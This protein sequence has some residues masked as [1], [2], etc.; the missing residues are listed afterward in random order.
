MNIWIILVMPTLLTSTSS[1]RN[2]SKQK[3]LARSARAI[4]P[5][6]NANDTLPAGDDD[7]L[8]AT[9]YPPSTTIREVIGFTAETGSTGSP[10]LQVRASPPTTG[11]M[12]G[13]A[14]TKPM[15]IVGVIMLLGCAGGGLYLWYL[16]KAKMDAEQADGADESMP[17]YQDEPPA[18]LDDEEEDAVPEP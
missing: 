5:A 11:A 12:T 16:R 2:L 17:Q 6:L 14:S 9:I 13:S 1:G 15:I 10:F 18:D 4:D 8:P 7:P 3:N